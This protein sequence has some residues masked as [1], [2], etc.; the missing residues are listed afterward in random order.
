MNSKRVAAIILAAG[1]AKR[2]GRPKQLIEWNGRPLIAHVVRQALEAALDPTVVVVGAYADQV[3]MAIEAITVPIVENRRWADGMSTS[4]QTGL[5]ALEP[6]VDAAIFLLVDQPHIDA[7]H[8]RAMVAAYQR[9][10]QPIVVSAY[11]G[12]RASPTLFDRSF[13]DQLMQVRGDS[14]G[15]SIIRAHPD[16][17]S[18]V[19][20]DDEAKLLDIDTQAD[21]DKAL[22]P[23]TESI[24]QEVA[25]SQTHQPSPAEAYRAQPE[26]RQFDFWLGEWNLN[27]G[28]DGAGTNSI[29]TILDGCI[30]QEN[31]RSDPKMGLDGMS[32]S[33]YDRH[34][35][36]WVQTWVDN[37][38]SY[39]DFTGEFKDGRMILQ[40][41]ALVDGRHFLQRMVW[42][43]IASDKLDWNWER[44]DDHGETWRVLW[45]IHYR[46]ANPA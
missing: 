26:A 22:K 24:S 46:R 9:S 3:R 40:R 30:I 8:L 35:D 25:M 2:M 21:L 27:W 38:G 5:A 19:E 28:E 15:R 34:R 44:S 6:D 37:Q 42:Y 16:R 12:R 14:G 1:E 17:V 7:A 33:A 10:R 31:F 20:V 36:K 45:H 11:Q 4:V 43:N 13:F 41:E 18:A 23:S 39:L 29:H 32:V